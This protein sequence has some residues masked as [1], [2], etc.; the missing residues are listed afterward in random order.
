MNDPVGKIEGPTT[1]EY[2]KPYNHFVR[3]REPR[4]DEVGK[5]LYAVARSEG[6]VRAALTFDA[7]RVANVARCLKWHPAGICYRG[8]GRACVAAQDAQPRA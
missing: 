1:G 8:I 3:L 7:F 4:D 6:D 2:G 5:Y